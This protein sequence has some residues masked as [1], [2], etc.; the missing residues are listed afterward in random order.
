MTHRIELET[1]T[2]GDVAIDS[3]IMLLSGAQTSRPGYRLTVSMQ[4]DGAQ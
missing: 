4:S 1:A 3:A 2:D